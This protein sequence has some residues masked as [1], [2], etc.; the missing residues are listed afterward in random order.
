MAGT[1]RKAHALARALEAVG[2]ALAAAPLADDR[3][4][5]ASDVLLALWLL[6]LAGTFARTVAIS[7]DRPARARTAA[8]GERS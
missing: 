7:A 4:A 5:E 3:A 6:G 2:V 8:R 1:S